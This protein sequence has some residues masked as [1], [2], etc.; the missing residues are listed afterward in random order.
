M[1]SFKSEW[2]WHL[3]TGGDSQ[4]VPFHNSVYGCCGVQ[5]DRYPCNGPKFSYVLFILFMYSFLGGEPGRA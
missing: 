2:Y 5:P 3:L 4:V 1:P